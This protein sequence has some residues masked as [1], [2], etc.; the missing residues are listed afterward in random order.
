MRARRR[1]LSAS[2]VVALA[3]AALVG[4]GAASTASAAPG[5]DN[6]PPLWTLDVGS[7]GIQALN[8]LALSP[9]GQ[10]YV[11]RTSSDGI[12]IYAAGATG[13]DAPVATIAGPSTQL[14]APYSLAFDSAG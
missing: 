7:S 9:S 14:T 10:L 6:T 3:V 4:A 2:G 8:G 11:D 13:T 5:D 12:L 1:A